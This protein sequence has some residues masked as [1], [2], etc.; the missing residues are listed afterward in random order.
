[1]SAMDQDIQENR[2]S[3]IPID[4]EHADDNTCCTF[5]IQNEDH[6][7]GGILRYI[8][9]KNPD[10]LF[11]GYNL[12]H[13]AE[14]VMHFRIQTNGKITAADAFRKGL[15]DIVEMADHM[16]AEFSKQAHGTNFQYVA[17]HDL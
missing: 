16:S 8:I 12:P 17:S 4:G 6:T 2:I 7:M 10:V 5:A 15:D 1:M 9:G 13:P 14:D 3:L 11:C